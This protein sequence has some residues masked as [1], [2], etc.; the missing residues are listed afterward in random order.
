MGC[1]GDQLPPV[2]PALRSVCDTRADDTRPFGA[3]ERV[4]V[5]RGRSALV[6]VLHIY[7]ER[8]SPQAALHTAFHQLPQRVRV[9]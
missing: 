4:G 2:V 7:P 9:R 3:P 8:D 5:G 6:A 1:A